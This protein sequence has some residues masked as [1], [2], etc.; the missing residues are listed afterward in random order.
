MLTF[1][2]TVARESEEFSRIYC[3]YQYNCRNRVVSHREVNGISK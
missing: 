3:I 1:T 2:N